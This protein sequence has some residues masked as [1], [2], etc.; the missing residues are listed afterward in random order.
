[1]PDPIDLYYPNY[2]SPPAAK[3]IVTGAVEILL[4]YLKGRDGDLILQGLELCD[5]IFDESMVA[6]LIDCVTYRADD[7]CLEALD[8]SYYVLRE[9][10]NEKLLDAVIERLDSDKNILIRRQSAIA[11]EAVPGNNKVIKALIRNLQEAK[12]RDLINDIVI[13]LD[14]IGAKSAID[15]LNK[16]LKEIEGWGEIEVEEA[17]FVIGSIKDALDRLNGIP[18]VHP[19]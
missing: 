13:T 18:S 9:T 3:A 15:A 17:D 11:L 4:G 7:I 10:Q 14:E 2:K 16:K 19:K 6:P 5:G 12:D 1:M 8:R